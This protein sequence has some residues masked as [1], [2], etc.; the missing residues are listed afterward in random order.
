MAARRVRGVGLTREGRLEVRR[1]I[2]NGRTFEQAAIAAT[3][4]TKTIQRVLGS[5]G[6]MPARGRTRAKLLTCL[7]RLVPVSRGRPVLQLCF[8]E[9]AE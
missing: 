7:K 6:G 8:G 1:H 4:S 2:E 9:P 5:V 3:C